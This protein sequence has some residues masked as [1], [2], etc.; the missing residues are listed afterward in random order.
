MIENCPFCGCLIKDCN[1]AQRK[2]RSNM[3]D[4]SIFL[5]AW[6]ES[7]VSGVCKTILDGAEKEIFLGNV[8]TII[9]GE[10]FKKLL[11]L[12]EES[13]QKSRYRYDEIYDNIVKSL[14]NFNPLYIC[15]DSINKYFGLNIRGEGRSQ[16]RLNLACAIQN[17]CNMFIVKDLGFTISQKNIPTKLIQIT[18][19]NNPQLRKLLN[20]IKCLQPL[21]G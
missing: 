18:D 3:I 16:D 1:C 20:E 12:K 2:L 17:N 5:E 10:I 13:S 4:S 7:D 9:L 11:E 21:D 15:N 6:D 19:K 14:T 8:S